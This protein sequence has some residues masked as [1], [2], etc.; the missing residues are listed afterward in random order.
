MDLA[1]MDSAGAACEGGDDERA[2]AFTP[3]VEKVL[4]E[5]LVGQTAR[6]LNIAF[7]EV[8]R[9]GENHVLNGFGPPPGAESAKEAWERIVAELQE[10]KSEERMRDLALI[11]AEKKC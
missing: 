4:E 3:G 5:G 11:A 2:A 9:L 7:A 6:Q 10:L 8:V 1:D